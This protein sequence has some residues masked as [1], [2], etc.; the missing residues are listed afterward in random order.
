M[1]YKNIFNITAQFSL[2]K[3]PKWL[4]N[5]REKYDK[6]YRYHLTFKTNTYFDPKYLREIKKELRGIAKKHKIN[7]VVFNKLSVRNTSKGWCIMI[8][9]EKNNE[10]LKIQ[11]DISSN[12]K[13][14]G[15][16]ISKEKERYENNFKPH[17]T[18]ARNLNSKQLKSA[19]K[20]LKEDILCKTIIRKLV[21]TTVNDDT[22][23]Q[24]NKFENRINYKLIN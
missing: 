12:L 1:S 22:S 11:K 7:K 4:D 17:I 19:K 9:A 16:N 6:P 15:K 24:W 21:L 14:Y 5:F 8:M 18:I 3:K 2:N 10:L 13:K 20:D 23:E